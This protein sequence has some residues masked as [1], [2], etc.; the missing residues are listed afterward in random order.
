MNVI[1]DFQKTQS[2]AS[3]IK[4]KIAK[5]REEK[6][7]RDKKMQ[8]EYQPWWHILFNSSEWKLKIKK[9]P[10]Y[11]NLYTGITPYDEEHF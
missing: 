9:E 11:I 1:N 10:T 8:L 2:F 5:K 7:K 6:L 3:N 4:S